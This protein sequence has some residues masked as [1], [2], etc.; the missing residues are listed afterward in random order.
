[1]LRFFYNKNA[2]WICCK[3]HLYIRD[4]H[5]ALIDDLLYHGFFQTH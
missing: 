5:Y 3:S 4:Y 1:M 2:H